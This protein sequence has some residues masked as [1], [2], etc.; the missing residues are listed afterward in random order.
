MT[1]YRRC[2]LLG[3]L[4]APLACGDGASSEDVLLSTIDDYAESLNEQAVVLCDCWED[5]GFESRGKCQEAN[6]EILPSKRRC[7][8]DAFARDVESSQ[9][10]LDC[11]QPLQEE[12]NECISEKLECDDVGPSVERCV[13]DYNTGRENCIDLPGT[14]ERAIEGCDS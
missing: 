14:I 4:L 7:Y 11:V 1:G 2:L 8:D 12:Y 9:D 6:G 3:F 5:A 10:F 13:D